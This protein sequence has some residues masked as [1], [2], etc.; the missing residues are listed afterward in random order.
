MA[1]FF[2]EVHKIF[3]SISRQTFGSKVWHILFCGYFSTSHETFFDF[4][5]NPHD[6][7]TAA[8]SNTAEKRTCSKIIHCQVQTDFAIA[9]HSKPET[10]E[11]DC[12][13][14]TWCRCIDLSLCCGQCQC[15]LWRWCGVKKASK[16]EQIS[17]GNW[18]RLCVFCPMWIGIYLKGIIT[19]VVMKQSLNR[20]ISQGY[21]CTGCNE[22]VLG[23]PRTSKPLHDQCIPEDTEPGISHK[24]LPGQKVKPYLMKNFWITGDIQENCNAWPIDTR[25]SSVQLGTGVK[26][27][28][29]WVSWSFLRFQPST[30]VKKN[31]KTLNMFKHV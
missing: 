19:R 18:S 22:A 12:I 24:P 30:V 15:F 13:I 2:Q 20:Y 17:W 26:F 27:V 31:K 23:G 8:Y 7:Q 1:Q 21:S 9:A 5:V 11:H 3:H 4:H 28:P 6:S 14:C 16:Q 10:M 25:I 29:H